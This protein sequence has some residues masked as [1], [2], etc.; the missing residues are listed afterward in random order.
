VKF[1]FLTLTYVSL[2]KEQTHD[3]DVREKKQLLTYH[4]FEV[5][6][7]VALNNPF[8]KLDDKKIPVLGVCQHLVHPLLSNKMSSF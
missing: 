7:S 1:F 2:A 3:Y 5:D 8:V 6:M 4:P